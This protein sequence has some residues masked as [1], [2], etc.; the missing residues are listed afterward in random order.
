LFFGIFIIMKSE[1]LVIEEL[2]RMKSLFGYER[3]RVISEQVV[4]GTPN[5]G[6]TTTTPAV[7]IPQA[8]APAATTLPDVTVTS[9]LTPRQKNINNAFCS[10]NNGVIVNPSSGQNNKKWADYVTE[11]TVT[12]AEIATSQKK[13]PNSGAA[14]KTASPR[15][16]DPKVMELQ[17]QLVAA[18][19]KLGNSGPNKDGVDGFMGAKTRLAQQQM[20]QQKGQDALK[21][22][23][24]QG[25]DFQNKRNQAIQQM[26]ALTPGQQ[27]NANA[28]KAG[29]PLPQSKAPAQTTTQ[30]AQPGAAVI[31]EKPTGL[32][33]AN[34]ER[35]GWY[36]DAK[37]KD[38]YTEPQ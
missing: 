18:G 9:T 16:P 24:K 38:W 12:A 28:L 25:Q 37:T 13:C 32:G 36:Y 21:N 27:A 3:G 2:S 6:F 14:V 35:D 7:P 10:V 15:K 20:I 34:E 1:K 19:Y 26:S 11:F 22:M 33:F 31:G 8:P 17:K 29:Q 4:P 30:T 23:T 5:Y